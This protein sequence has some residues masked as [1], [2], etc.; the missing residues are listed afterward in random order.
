MVLYVE[1]GPDGQAQK[2]QVQRGVGLGLDDKAV[3][4]VSKW[5]FSPG[6]RFGVPVTVAATIEDNFRAL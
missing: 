2:I 5:R 1:I 4:A 6:T 3:E